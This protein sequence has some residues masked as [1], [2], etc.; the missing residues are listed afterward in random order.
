MK[1]TAI[2]LFN[3]G[4][5]DSLKAV[6][7][8]LFNLFFDPAIIRVPT[9]FRWC[10]AHFIST[11]RRAKACGIYQEMG[12]KSPI[13]EQTLHQALSLEQ[14]LKEKGNGEYKCFIA[15]R[16]WHPM[17]EQVA[18]NVKAYA[19]DQIILLPLYP[20]YS[21]TTTGSS[22]KE[23]QR[24]AEKIQLDVPTRTICCYP[25]E[26]SFVA[27]H[28]KLI[29]DS[30]WKASEYGKPRILFSAHGLPE[31]IVKEGDPY[32]YQVE[33]TVEA[34][35]Q[36]MAVDGLDYRICYQ[37]RVGPLKWIGPSTDEEIKQAGADKVPV[38]LVPVAFV[39]EHSETLVELD[40]EYRHLA[41]EHGV[42][43]YQRVRALCTDN[44]FI[45]SLAQ[46][47]IMPDSTATTSHTGE[48]FCSKEWK[49][50]PCK[51]EGK[52]A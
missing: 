45:E 26:R 14:A 48:R 47:C 51:S 52:A 15:M 37:S 31:K 34:I 9:F 28:V 3:L 7:P 41:K 6:R 20:Q 10:L 8:F 40:I 42:P 36:I 24:V 21:T 17:S 16:Y 27:S 44:H 5:P 22:V 1:K 30:Y 29:K 2:I 32:Q 46:L 38:V 35:T 50:C 13:L 25:T 19:P 43:D 33:K 4:G 49:E 18:K 11:K 39:S 23:W 12:G